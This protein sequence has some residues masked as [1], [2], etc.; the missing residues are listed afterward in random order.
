MSK[1]DQQARK[2]RQAAMVIAGTALFWVLAGLIGEKEGFSMRLRLLF[3][4]LAL[5]GFVFAF[6]LI[7]QLWRDRRDNQG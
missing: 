4:L 6:W 2:G 5:A 3:D 1:S 7:F